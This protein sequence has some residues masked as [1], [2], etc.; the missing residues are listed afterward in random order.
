MEVVVD[1]EREIYFLDNVKV[2]LD[3]VGGLGTFVEIEAQGVEGEASEQSL[4][5]QCRQ[6][7]S[8]F[9]LDEGD[10]LAESYSDLI[11]AQ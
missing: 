10:F 8:D 9:G 11:L 6:L 2:H 7:I 3:R 1:K 4:D 5:E